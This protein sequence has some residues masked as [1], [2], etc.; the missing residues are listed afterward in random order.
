MQHRVV[1]RVSADQGWA[2]VP[3]DDAE[4]CGSTLHRRSLADSKEPVV[5]MNANKRAPARG[6]FVLI[7]LHLEGLNTGDLHSTVSFIVAGTRSSS[8]AIL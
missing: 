6:V 1:E 7:P 3:F 5:R 8:A 4:R 2:D